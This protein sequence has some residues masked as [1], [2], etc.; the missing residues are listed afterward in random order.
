[1]RYL[2]NAW[3]ILK[4]SPIE[5]GR[6]KDDK[7]VKSACGTAYLAV[8]KVIDD[9]LLRKGLTKKEMPK[10]VEAYRKALQKYLSSYD[11]KLL[12]QFEDIYDDLHIGGYYRGILHSVEVVKGAFTIAEDFIKK[13]SSK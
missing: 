6:F 1:M 10:S 2:A 8:L 3:E 11:G 5:D 9:H 13:V 12:R 7:Y 4:K